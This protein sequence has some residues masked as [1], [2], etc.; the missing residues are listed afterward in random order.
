MSPQV[1]DSD[2]TEEPSLKWMGAMITDDT[3]L[4]E[5]DD[6]NRTPA[7]GV[8]YYVSLCHSHCSRITDSV[9]SKDLM[10]D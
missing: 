4:L 5:A 1:F 3:N 10:V 2:S 8:S 9:T 6:S 7:T